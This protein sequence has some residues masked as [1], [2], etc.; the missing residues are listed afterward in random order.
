MTA[1][2]TCLSIALLFLCGAVGMTV[3]IFRDLDK[4]E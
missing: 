1:F 2:E 4:D 3:F